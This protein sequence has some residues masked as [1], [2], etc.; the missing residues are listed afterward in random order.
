MVR[1]GYCT[2]K[3]RKDG[4]FFFALVRCPV[5]EKIREKSVGFIILILDFS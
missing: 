1:Y 4:N 2:D 3:D 5:R